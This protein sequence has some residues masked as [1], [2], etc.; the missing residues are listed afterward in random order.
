MSHFADEG[1]N[2]LILGEAHGLFCSPARFLRPNFLLCVRFV[3]LIL[4]MKD[5]RSWVLLGVIGFA[6]RDQHRFIARVWACENELKL[7]LQKIATPLMKLSFRARIKAYFLS[8]SST[9]F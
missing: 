6:P 1:C 4:P 2:E 5:A 8:K 7:V 3:F 9:G